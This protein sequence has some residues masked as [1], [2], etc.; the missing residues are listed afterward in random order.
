MDVSKCIALFEE[1]EFVPDKYYTLDGYY[2]FIEIVSLQSAFSVLISIPDK[3]KLPS[4]KLKHEYELIAKE[5][6]LD[7]FREV[8]DTEMR[9]AYRNI[10]NLDQLLKNENEFLDLYDKPI[11]LKGE[12]NKSKGKFAVLL[13]QM[14][15]LQLCFKTIDYKPALFDHDCLVVMQ[16]NKMQS[17]FISN[18]GSKKRRFLLIIPLTNFYANPKIGPSVKAILTQFYDILNNNQQTETNKVQNML[19][20]KRNIVNSSKKILERK[21]FYLRQIAEMTNNHEK[22]RVQISIFQRKLESS[23][24]EGK[25]EVDVRN[26]LVQDIN[27][28]EEKSKDLVR[29]ILEMNKLLDELVLE[30]DHILFDNMT[31]LSEISLNFRM[32]EELAK[33]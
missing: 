23:A 15:R 31:M 17:Y 9:Q 1:N 33:N 26:R 19:E 30:V 18:C 22:I 10:D 8:D 16:E 25:Q 29:K 13:R 24:A 28:L 27:N 32:L 20:Q 7:F 4:N 11:S 14:K 6:S 3:Y 12:E 2:R 5:S 21:K